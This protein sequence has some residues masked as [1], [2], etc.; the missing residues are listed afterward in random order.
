MMEGNLVHRIC[1]QVKLFQGTCGKNGCVGA[2]LIYRCYIDNM[3]V[4]L[5]EFIVWDRNS[6]TSAN[7]GGIQIKWRPLLQSCSELEWNLRVKAVLCKEH[8]RFPIIRPPRHSKE[9]PGF[10]NCKLF[11]SPIEV[12]RGLKRVYLL[13]L[14]QQLMLQ[15]FFQLKTGSKAE[16]NGSSIKLYIN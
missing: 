11:V 10:N 8:V 3:Q 2:F 5:P 15:A 14:S 13:F 6:T 7:F 1:D 12:E 9:V 4:R 16:P